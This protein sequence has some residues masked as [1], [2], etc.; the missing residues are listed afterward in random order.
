MYLSRFG[1]KNYKCLGDIDI[2]LTPIHV[3][4]GPND[5]GKTSLLEALAAFHNTSQRDLAEVFPEPWNG[6]ELVF[7]GAA[8]P[9]VQFSGHW[10]PSASEPTTSQ[11]SEIGYGLTVRFA[12]NGRTCEVW[13]ELVQTAGVPVPL[14]IH[15]QMPGKATTLRFYMAHPQQ[16]RSIAPG[17]LLPDLDSLSVVIKPTHIWRFDP[18]Q[19]AV[20]AAIR[21]DRKF[22]MDPDGFGLP[23]LLGDIL[24]RSADEYVRL[25]NGFCELFP[26]FRDIRMQSEQ[27]LWRE[28]KHGAAHPHKFAT[29]LA[30]YL[31]TR[32]GHTVRAQQASDGAIL[33]LGFLA[34]AHLPDPPTLVLLEEPENGIYPKRLAEVIQLLKKMVYREEGPRFPQII[35]TTHSP[36]V[37]S[38]FEPEEVTFLSRDPNKPEAGVRA[39]PLRT[40]PRIREW[41]AGGAFY[42]GEV[43]YNLSEEEL[44]G[45]P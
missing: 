13:E 21:Q 37:L 4:I 27:G 9:N 33:F 17:G 41:L 29:G 10:S 35:L 8:E 25:R 43:W 19:M 22:T 14:H 30:I 3:L 15:P 34:L 12:D 26:D 44:F 18:R 5:A 7:H 11:G 31:E 45:E 42:L 6:R 1:V 24:L 36:Y 2:P 32:S 40:A 28:W 38:F 23:A 16:V 20:P 39:R